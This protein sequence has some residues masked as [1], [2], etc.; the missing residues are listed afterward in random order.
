MV[1][2]PNYLITDNG[3]RAYYRGGNQPLRS[4]VRAQNDDTR[5]FELVPEAIV[6]QEGIGDDKQGCPNSGQQCA[7]AGQCRPAAP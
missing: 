5:R 7:G 6:S 1:S 2:F 3:L 4:P